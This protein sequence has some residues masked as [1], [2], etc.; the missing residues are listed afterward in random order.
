MFSPLEQFEI[1]SLFNLTFGFFDIS[2]SNVILPLLLVILLIFFILSLTWK[3]WLLVPTSWQVFLYF[4]Y[5]FILQIIMQ[6]IGIKGVKYY[7]FIF[8]IFFYILCLN[9]LSLLPFGIAITSHII[10]ILYLS[11]TLWG[12]IFFI[13]LINYNISFLRIFIP[14]CPFI[15]LIL[16]IPIEIFSYIIRMFSLAIRLVANILAGHT[17]VYI[18]TN[19]LIICLNMR[20]WFYFIGVILLFLILILEFG[21]AFSQAYI[22]TILICIYLNDS[23]NFGEH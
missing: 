7:C 5:N 17:L 1:V 15:L 9:L 20:F 12:G 3:E 10:V 6:Q 18:I 22:F 11:I 19:F 16:L 4:M 23:I 2:L 8:S 21:V 13:G 14:N